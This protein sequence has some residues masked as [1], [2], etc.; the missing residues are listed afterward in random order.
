MTRL[1]A[2]E[3]ELGQQRFSFFLTGECHTRITPLGGPAA[4][5]PLP[6]TFAVTPQSPR[7]ETNCQYPSFRSADFIRAR[8]ARVSITA[9]NLL[10]FH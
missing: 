2:Q 7:R 4:A 3:K 6:Q 1:L 5:R 9:S 10:G 8:L